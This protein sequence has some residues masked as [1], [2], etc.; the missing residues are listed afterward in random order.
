MQTALLVFIMIFALAI[1]FF[2]G[3]FLISLDAPFL[4]KL[5]QKEETEDTSP[6][7]KPAHPSNSDVEVSPALKKPSPGSRLMLQVWKEE[8]QPPIYEFN[9]VYVSKE[10]LPQ[11]LLHV[12]TIQEEAIKESVPPSEPADEKPPAET[13]QEIENEDEVEIPLLSVVDEVNKILQHK[14]HGSPLAGKGILMMENHDKE[15]RFWVGL[16]SYSDVSEIPDSEIQRI[17]N[18]AVREW[19]QSRG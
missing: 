5:F 6:D 15:I 3:L 14:L 9:G 11:E 10:K 8:G 19:E 1:G 2:L 17:I 4:K 7:Y 18:E 12:I 13:P 16:K